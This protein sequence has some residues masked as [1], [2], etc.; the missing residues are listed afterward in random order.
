MANRTVSTTMPV[1]TDQASASG[2]VTLGSVRS[3]GGTF[4]VTLVHAVASILRSRNTPP[5]TAPGVTSGVLEPSPFLALFLPIRILLAPFS[6]ALSS[7]GLPVTRLGAVR[8]AGLRA[9]GPGRRPH[10]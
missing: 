9:G 2:N 3:V 7:H 8:Q 1:A 10:T 5:F 4:P 6:D